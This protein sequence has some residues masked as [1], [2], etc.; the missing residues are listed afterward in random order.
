MTIA[1]ILGSLLR[2]L[3]H[4]PT[5]PPVVTVEPDPEPAPVMPP[6]PP[7]VS[8]PVATPSPY[9]FTIHNHFIQPSRVSYSPNRSGPFTANRPDLIVIHYTAGSTL[10]GA[11][12]WL[13]SLDSKASAHLVIGKDGRVVQMV[14][15]DEI[16]WH[17]GVSSYQGSPS[18]NHR[19]IGIELVNRGYGVPAGSGKLL[20]HKNESIPRWWDLYQD[21][22][23]DSLI[24]VCKAIRK[25]YPIVNIVGHDDVAPSRKQDPGPAFPWPQFRLRVLA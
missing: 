12:S 24:A 19:A 25:V 22:Q 16:A 8:P 15:F 17:A 9:R 3:A 23:I 21:A 20:T 1:E 2:L 6:L 13:K 4:K 18:V 10:D 5:K 7:P 11:V 14:P